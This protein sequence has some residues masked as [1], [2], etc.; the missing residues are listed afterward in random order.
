MIDGYTLEV[1]AQR[2]RIEAERR[3]A[4]ARLIYPAPR[5][6]ETWM[7]GRG[8][9]TLI[10]AAR[11]FVPGHLLGRLRLGPAAVR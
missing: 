8:L 1:A 3:A 4:N 6:A 11:R 9:H 5:S 2:K 7:P 10:V